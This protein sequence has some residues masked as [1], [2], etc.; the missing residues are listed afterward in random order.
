MVVGITGNP[1]IGKSTNQTWILCQELTYNCMEN[2]SI[3]TKMVSNWVAH[4]DI[5]L[6]C[7]Y[8]DYLVKSDLWSLANNIQ[9]IKS[10]LPIPSCSRYLVTCI[11]ILP[12][13]VKFLKMFL[14]WTGTSK[15]FTVWIRLLYSEIL[16]HP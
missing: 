4:Q 11:M 7:L 5:P 10:L 16:G 14:L 6:I 9:T 15:T 13:T 3:V 8:S 2:G 1:K 12:N